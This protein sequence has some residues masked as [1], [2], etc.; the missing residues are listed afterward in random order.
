MHLQ[1]TKRLSRKSGGPQYYFHDLQEAVR[2]YL[3]KKGAVPVALVTPYGPTKTAY[4]AVSCDKKLDGDGKP[5]PGNVGHDRIQQAKAPGSMGESVRAWYGLARGDFERIGVDVDICDDTF[6]LTP[7]DYKL[8]GNERSVPLAAAE[9]PLT[10]PRDYVSKFWRDQLASLLRGKSKST[11]LWSLDEIRKIARAHIDKTPHIQEL[12]LLR[13]HGSL[14]QLGLALGPYVGRGYDCRSEFHFGS[15][16]TYQVPVEIKRHSKG[17]RYQMQK[18]GRE[19]LSR[20]VVL[21]AIHDLHKVPR[22]VDVIELAAI[23]EYPI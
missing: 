19:E 17:F 7:T 5:V 6:Y 10:F 4:V 20:A 3:R 15:L 13:A 23:A 21:C 18:Y 16:P 12:D 14:V 9:R 22:Y 8:A 11:I 2:V 1:Q